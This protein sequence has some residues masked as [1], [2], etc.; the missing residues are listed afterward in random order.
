VA[1]ILAT[2]VLAGIL[3]GPTPG[4]AQPPADRPT[5]PP[6][7]Q[8][9]DRAIDAGERSEVIAEVLK[10]LVKSYVYPD[11]AKAMEAAIR[12]RQNNG[13]Y[14]TV[15]SAATLART[16]TTHLRAVSH[17]RHLHVDYRP[18]IGGSPG[19]RRGPMNRDQM[20]KR[21]AARNFGFKKL[22]RLEGNVGYL[23]LE[24]FLPAEF[25][26]ETAAAAMSFLANTDALIIDLR[27][28]GGGD[29]S[30]VAFLCS[31]FF[32]GRP[33]HLN[34]LYH[35][36]DDT[37]HQWWTL[38]HV[39][40]RRYLGKDVYILT[41]KRTFSAAE[42]FAYDLQCLKRATIVGEATG[43]GAHPGFG[44]RI[45]DHFM[46]FV[47]TGR[48]INPIT[49]TNWEGTGVK[50]DV[51]AL[52]EK[53]LEIAHRKAREKLREGRDGETVPRVAPGG[54]PEQ[55]PSAPAPT[56]PGVRPPR[57]F[58]FGLTPLMLLKYKSVQDDLKLT[59][60]QVAVVVSA[61]ETEMRTFNRILPLGPDEHAQRIKELSQESD[62]LAAKILNPA[63]AN[64]L[65][66]ISLQ[67]QGPRAF[68]DPDLVHELGLTEEQTQHIGKVVAET[69]P[70]LGQV[71]QPGMT[72]DEANRKLRELD[73]NARDKILKLLTAEQLAKWKEMT[74]E[75]FHGRVGTGSPGIRQIRVTP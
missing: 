67:V 13:E 51:E 27:H 54:A 55:A 49:K 44:R 8:P 34:D 17:D 36:P 35:R 15:T 74:G 22:E 11:K 57:P 59:P 48:A 10:E 31:Y 42:E 72:P 50:P 61:A 39:P 26:A 9:P 30:M 5:A 16:L 40:G 47:P 1:G 12:A 52:A 38:P 43:G 28:N 23:E 73:K 18:T 56:R 4:P 45:N 41:S 62:R 25:A 68:T 29:P 70:H 2:L 7:Q 6:A 21:F 3:W 69:N 60:A 71:I 53:A 58:R 37:T 75:A 24:M 66:Q 63:Q 19:L 46:M 32:D 33:V 14:D 65:R 20:T 64:R